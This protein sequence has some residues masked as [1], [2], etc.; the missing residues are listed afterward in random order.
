MFA[1]ENAF[2]IKSLI[3]A[4][5]CRLSK[6]VQ[7]V[8]E[9]S[10][11]AQIT[12]ETML[13]SEIDWDFSKQYVKTPNKPKKHQKEAIKDSLEKLKRH[14][15]GKLI[16]ACGTGKTLVSLH[17]VEKNTKS[18][19]IVLYLV[20]SIA[21][22]PQ[23]L[24][25]YANN[26]TNLF[27]Y[28]AVCSDKSAG[29][30]TNDN[31]EDVTQIQIQSSTNPGHLAEKLKNRD[32]TRKMVVFSTYNSI[33][34]VI[35]AMEKQNIPK[36]RMILFDEAHR[37]AG[38]KL[39]NNKTSFYA[40]GLYDKF[41][42]ADK[43]VFM[44]ATPRY[45]GKNNQKKITNAASKFISMDDR[46]LYG[47]TLHYLGFNKAQKDGILVPFDIIMARPKEDN[48]LAQS[49]E[50]DLVNLHTTKLRY[51]LQAIK[52]PDG[53]GTK[54]RLLQRVLLFNNRIKD[55]K[56]IAKKLEEN[57]KRSIKWVANEYH[58][59]IKIDI[60]HVDAS[61]P[62]VDRG[63][64]I[65]WLKE[66]DFN[67]E[68][69]RILTNAR[70]L[71]EGVD[72]PS[73]DC[74]V[75]M[76]PKSS[77]IDIIQSIGRVMRKP[78]F[79]KNK[80]KGYVAVPVL[81]EHDKDKK[82]A[83]LN[84]DS[85]KTIQ[86]VITAIASHDEALMSLINQA[87]LVEPGTKGR[88]KFRWEKWPI[89]N[90]I[91]KSLGDEI[92]NE[93][94]DTITLSLQDK[95][96]FPRHGRRLGEA[97]LELEQ[98]LA[99][100]IKNDKTKKKTMFEFHK[101]LKKIVNIQ[102]TFSDVLKLLSQHI[103]MHKIFNMLF[104]E[105]F[106]NNMSALLEST[107]LKLKLNDLPADLSDNL[108]DVYLEAETD[109]NMM[110]DKPEVIQGF[111]KNLYDSFLEGSSP[112]DSKKHGAVYTP[113]EVV[114][115]VI[116]SVEH[117][118][119]TEFDCSFGTGNVNVL[120]PFTGTGSF[121]TRLLQSGLIP[122]HKLEKMYKENI[123][124]ND[125]LL[126]AYYV[127]SVNIETVYKGMVGKYEPF[128]GINYV[129]TFEQN[130]KY[131]SEGDLMHKRRQLKITSE[132]AKISENQRRS[133]QTNI[134]VIITNPPW[135]VGQK[136]ASDD[137][138]NVR[139]EIVENNIKNTYNTKAREVGYKGAITGMNNLYI[140][141]FRWASD[142]IGECGV[143]GF[144]TPASFITANSTVGMRA[145]LEKE[146]SDIWIF[147]LR[148]NA[149]TKGKTRRKERGNIFTSGTKEPV[150][151]TILV[152]N[153]NKH[154]CTIHYS[155]L[156]DYLSIES[157]L[158]QIKKLNS[159]AGIEKK[160]WK[161]IIPDCQHNWLDQPGK[162]GK[163]FQKHIPMGTKEAKRDKDNHTMF[164]TYSRGIGTS[165]DAW[166]Y[167][168]SK[169]VL[170]ENMKRMIKYCNDSIRKKKFIK[171][172]KLGAYTK[173]MEKKIKGMKQEFSEKYISTVLYRPFFKQECYFDLTFI[174]AA[175][176]IPSF[177]PNNEGL[178]IT[179]P[180]KIK[181]EFSPFVSDGLLDL[182]LNETLQTFPL[183]PSEEQA[184]PPPQQPAIIIPDKNWGKFSIFITKTK[185]DLEVVHHGQCFPMG[186]VT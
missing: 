57:D 85:F 62:S 94:V 71:A 55:S 144:V 151:L 106:N 39:S 174:D 97:A 82:R 110:L 153:S 28:A 108:E 149:T 163:E 1:T 118:L 185:P 3:L 121:I 15:R 63:K 37:T 175:N 67:P 59:D 171:D 25:E 173:G 11:H 127:A 101:E 177:F 13:E 169:T 126:L 95:S 107:I 14:N 166:A 86:Q 105:G 99:K 22:I 183:M 40:K 114:D 158:K 113:I 12:A 41:I 36:L 84:T 87:T 131:H 79:D 96:Y 16:M 5:T 20:P 31:I 6:E 93:L 64:A 90:G 68:E 152:K 52:Q 78:D 100:M 74:V 162:A 8:L 75:F 38:F 34:V 133:K 19:D 112:K 167:N 168:T 135:S 61:T 17:L 178:S 111:V 7:Y 88:K 44:T 115:F 139:H 21:L 33:D 49:D 147:G 102:I 129:D 122:K 9:K 116:N 56:T 30:T 136:K 70:C 58:K 23:T 73:L 130:P 184:A 180:D 60:K 128:L 51:V 50:Q 172:P 69:C 81:V 45:N 140:K 42:K 47:N 43:R 182:H 160:D 72:V 165:R 32:K 179:V 83:F 18:G 137:N 132:G 138:M 159:I 89:F 154:K 164:T 141:A 155:Q 157:K 181:G 48:K 29:K 125:V 145:C 98:Y 76:Q 77:V 150:V 148:G 92:F 24:K 66:S 119:K 54:N 186:V 124:A 65:R 123:Y 27:E 91:R 104:P 26:S 134:T 146:F 35:A 109:I 4:H 161:E 117:A 143:I 2:D 170:T 142:R 103:V 46:E 176:Q 80:T 10:N 53:I 156:D 120:D